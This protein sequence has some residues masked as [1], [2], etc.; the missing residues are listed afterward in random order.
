MA[1]VVDGRQLTWDELGQA[2]QNEGWNFTITLDEPIAMVD[3]Y[4]PTLAFGENEP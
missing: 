2:I 3:D 1:V 4:D